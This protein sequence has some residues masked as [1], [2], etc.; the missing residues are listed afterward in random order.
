MNSDAGPA[1]RK[2]VNRYFSFELPIWLLYLLCLLFMLASSEVGFR[3]GRRASAK[4]DEAIRSRISI[5][6]SAILGVLGLLMGFTMSMA[7]TRYD[8]RRL[9]VVQEAN[10]IGTTWLRS[11]MMPAPEG[12]EFA[13]LLREYVDVRLRYVPALGMDRMPELRA[14]GKRLQNE[15]WL[16]ASGFALRDQR[17]VPA[18]LLLQSLNESIDLEGARWAAFWGRVPQS[19]IYVNV[20]IAMLAAELLGYGFGL[21]GKRHMVSTVLLAVSI[22]GVLAVIVDLD[23]P[24]QGFIKISQQPMIDLQKDLA[25]PR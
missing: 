20:L 25:N 1:K 2:T 18:G 22:S 5:F 4:F 24:W 15:L 7:V 14:Q 21:V 6:E 19:V 23:R 10:A 12:S 8:L 16:R 9:L 13:G 17:S 3:A 11:K